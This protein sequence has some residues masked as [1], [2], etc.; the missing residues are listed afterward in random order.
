MWWTSLPRSIGLGLGEAECTM[1]SE[2]EA[3]VSANNAETAGLASFSGEFK[4]VRDHHLVGGC[5]YWK[6]PNCGSGCIIWT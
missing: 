2:L 1:P 4:P 5:A 6:T 3:A